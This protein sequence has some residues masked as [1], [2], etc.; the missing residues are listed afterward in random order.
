LLLLPP[1]LLLLPPLLLLLLLLLLLPLPLLPLFY[2]LP[3][4]R[5]RRP[6]LLSP[7]PRPDRPQVTKEEYAALG[8]DALGAQLVEALKSE[9]RKP[10]FIP[11]GGS[12]S[13]VR[14]GRGGHQTLNPK[15]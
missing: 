7:S 1:L 15:P 6:P 2:G 3:H 9:G 10:Y 5:P 14:R 4:K 8:G 12:N 11:V 13:L